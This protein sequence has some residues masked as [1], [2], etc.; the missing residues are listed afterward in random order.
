MAA[1]AC[2]APDAHFGEGV[3]KTPASPE[4]LA[5]ERDMFERLNR[6][7]AAGGLPPLAYDEDLAA[8]GRAHSVDMHDH[9]FFAH[10]SPTTGTIENRLDRAGYLAIVGRENL[11]EANDV[12]TA[13]AG[14]MK[15]PGHHANIMANDVAKI[16]IGIVKGGVLDPENFLFTQVFAKP[17]VA[18][19]PSRLADDVA[20]RID[21]ARKSAG[22]SPVKHDGR[23]RELAAAHVA[24]L[25]GSVDDAATSRVAD[26]VLKDLAGQGGSRGIVVQAAMVLD[27]SMY[28]LPEAALLPI[29]SEYG[30]AAHEAR[31]AHQRPALEVLLLALK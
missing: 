15:S 31:D 29:I 10:E 16:G 5:M 3:P 7:R 18:V 6:D 22:L 26:R 2:G 28:E 20:Q 8:I 1:V 9:H 17:A 27:A 19:T 4:I 14:L 24:E 12:P 11:A 13:Q 25:G 21:A 23:L 30:V